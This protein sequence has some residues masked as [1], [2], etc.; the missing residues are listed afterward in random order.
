MHLELIKIKSSKYQQKKNF[1]KMVFE[2]LEV[3]SMINFNKNI[4]I[5]YENEIKDYELLADEYI[6]FLIYEVL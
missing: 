1:N 6:G 4:Q 3:I 2:I 5:E